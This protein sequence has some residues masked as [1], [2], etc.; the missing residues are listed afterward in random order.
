M[1]SHA[2]CRGAVHKHQESLISICVVNDDTHPLSSSRNADSQS[3]MSQG[4]PLPMHPIVVV[5]T[6]QRYEN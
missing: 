2:K 3:Q 4:Y 6:F 5:S 1:D